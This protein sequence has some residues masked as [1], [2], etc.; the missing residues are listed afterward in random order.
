MVDNG[1]L[2]E[3]EDFDK[4]IQS[5]EITDGV[6]LTKALGLKELRSYLNGEL[7]KDEAITLAQTATRHYAK[8]QMT[9]FRNQL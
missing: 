5:G 8:R 2:E 3:I 9:W 6:P 1:A 4:R 7:S